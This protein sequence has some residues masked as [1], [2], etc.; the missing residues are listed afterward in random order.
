VNDTATRSP[1]IKCDGCNKR[2]TETQAAIFSGMAD[3]RERHH[4]ACWPYR[5][6]A[7][8]LLERPAS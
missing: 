8:E 3:E 5:P 1:R 6:R 7:V 4:L 2:I